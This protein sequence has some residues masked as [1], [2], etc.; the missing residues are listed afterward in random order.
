MFYH[1]FKVDFACL[2]DLEAIKDAFCF[3]IKDPC[4]SVTL[5]PLAPFRAAN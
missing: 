5:T 4:Q 1:L 3:L 2:R